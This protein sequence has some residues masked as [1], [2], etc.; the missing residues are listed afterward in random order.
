LTGT[1][2]E[3]SILAIIYIFVGGEKWQYKRVE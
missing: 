3:V 2:V 1:I